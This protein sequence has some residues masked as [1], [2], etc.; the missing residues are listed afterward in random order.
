MVHEILGT[1]RGEDPVKGRP[2]WNVRRR[3]V[4]CG[5]MLAA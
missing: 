4:L 1:V 3:R 2:R 5:V